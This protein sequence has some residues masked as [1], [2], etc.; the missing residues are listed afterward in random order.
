MTDLASRS[1]S[2]PTVTLSRQQSSGLLATTESEREAQR[3][4][5]G[6]TGDKEKEQK[7]DESDLKRESGKRG[8]NSAENRWGFVMKMSPI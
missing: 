8:G 1:Q 6:D 3:E 5:A 2:Y 7:R 4:T